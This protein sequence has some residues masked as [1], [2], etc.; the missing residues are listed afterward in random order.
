M[1]C[2]KCGYKTIGE[3]AFCHKCG[4]KIVTN[5]TVNYTLA[6]TPEIQRLNTHASEPKKENSST[7]NNDTQ[8][9]GREKMN[10]LASK[11]KTLANT[12]RVFIITACLLAVAFIIF[13]LIKVTWLSLFLILSAGG[14]WLYTRKKGNPNARKLSIVLLS[15]AGIIAAVFIVIFGIRIIG[16]VADEISDAYDSVFT[17]NSRGNS[18]SRSSNSSSRSSN[19][20]SSNSNSTSRFEWV[21][22]PKVEADYIGGGFIEGVYIAPVKIGDKIV[23]SIKN[24]SNETF[25]MVTITFT[26]YDSAGNQI[27]TATSSVSNFRPG[28][29]WK[30]E[31]YIWNSKASRF[32]FE[33]ITAY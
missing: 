33:K 16:G 21:D 8:V 3:S 23:G 7:A 17:S 28:N 5:E 27:D 11:F 1:F 13:V 25:S 2:H 31:A 14:G 24:I 29:T 18:T 20:S 9:F 32:E 22:N 4:T 15:G 12:E 19:T 30:F 10:S 26:L 6:S